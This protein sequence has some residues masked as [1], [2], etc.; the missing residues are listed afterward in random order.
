MPKLCFRSSPLTRHA[1]RRQKHQRL[2]WMFEVCRDI[3][4]TSRLHLCRQAPLTNILAQRV[5]T[6]RMITVSLPSWASRLLCPWVP[7]RGP[8]GKLLV[9][10]RRHAF[11]HQKTTPKSGPQNFEFSTPGPCDFFPVWGTLGAQCSATFP[12]QVVTST[13]AA[14]SARYLQMGQARDCFSIILAASWI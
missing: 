14:N 7:K 1:R 12:G 10:F 11:L 3:A 5:R 2:R 9:A 6:R 13:L 4:S 8:R